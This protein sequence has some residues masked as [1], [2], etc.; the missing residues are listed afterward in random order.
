MSE[1][2][3]D[4][5]VVLFQDLMEIYRSY[6]REAVSPGT[7]THK[8]QEGLRDSTE[9]YITRRSRADT[10]LTPS[11]SPQLPPQAIHQMTQGSTMASG[12]ASS[13]EPGTLESIGATAICSCLRVFLAPLDDTLPSSV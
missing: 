6:H 13:G 10:E 1:H 4:S 7:P 9:Q 12:N 3:L 8:Y 11:L 5:H 2:A